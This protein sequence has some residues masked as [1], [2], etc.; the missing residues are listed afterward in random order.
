[1]TS[2]SGVALPAASTSGALEAGVEGAQP[3]IVVPRAPQHRRDTHCDPPG[4]AGAGR[5]AQLAAAGMDV[6]GD[7]S[8]QTRF[9]AVLDPGDKDSA[10]VTP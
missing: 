7:A 6:T 8:V 5:W 1:M 9:A 10:I 2:A 3:A 4:T